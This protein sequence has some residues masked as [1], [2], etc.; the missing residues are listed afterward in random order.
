[1]TENES[2]FLADFFAVTE[3]ALLFGMGQN[4]PTGDKVCD[5]YL[6]DYLR[7]LLKIR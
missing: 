3:K 6:D 1:M 7:F 5:L 4:F 2:G